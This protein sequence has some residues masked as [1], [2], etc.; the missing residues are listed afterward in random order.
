MGSVTLGGS[1]EVNSNV[2][3]NKNIYDKIDTIQTYQNSL[4]IEACEVRRQ[5]DRIN[6]VDSTQSI[7][8]YDSSGVEAS[9]S[10]EALLPDV[11]YTS[12]S[13]SG[14]SR[15]TPRQ[16]K[17]KWGENTPLIRGPRSS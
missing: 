1:D 7:R 15:N 11:G 8:S 13:G 17:N 4:E 2:S 6:S 16:K 10:G 9:H 12:A 14:N 3:N 5:R